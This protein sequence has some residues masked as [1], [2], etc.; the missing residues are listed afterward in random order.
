MKGFSIA[1]FGSS[2]VSS[3]WNGAATYYRGLICA[4]HAR[5]HRVTFYEPDAFDRQ[6]H[7]D[8]EDPPWAKVQVYSATEEGVFRSL[9]AAMGADI[10]VKA[11]GVGVFDELLEKEVLSLKTADNKVVFWD[12]DAPATLERISHNPHDPFRS[13]IPGY[14][15]IL[16]YGGGDP[17]VDGYGSFGARECI[18]V[19]NALD[20]DTHHPVPSDHRFCA[21]LAF[22]GNRLPDREKRV[23]E[24][25]LRTAASL[26][27]KR[28]LLAGSGW[29]DKQ[30]PRNVDYLGHLGTASHNAFNCSPLAVLNISR[31]SMAKNGFSPAT[32][33]FEAAGA[34]TCIITDSWQGIEQFFE[35]GKEI[36]VAGSG[37]EVADILER[38][39]PREASMVGLHAFARVRAEHTYA[40]RARQVE[41]I[42]MEEESSM[43]SYAGGAA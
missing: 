31:E 37:E 11:S 18:P 21:D 41:A 1:F 17:V 12:V 22:L 14:D 8:M 35:P 3:Y 13:L 36:L 32:R 39:T 38:L 28:F 24:F 34:G 6:Q 7:R 16:T 23:E 30:R 20:P 26:P 33:V 25:F 42:F 10:V 43:G 15:L 5:G 40:H 2:L 9:E 4:L 19:Y 29:D 27:H